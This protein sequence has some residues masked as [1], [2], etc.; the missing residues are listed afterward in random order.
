VSSSNEAGLVWIPPS[1]PASYWLTSPVPGACESGEQP[2]SPGYL[3]AVPH[4]AIYV[5]HVRKAAGTDSPINC[6]AGVKVRV[7][8]ISPTSSPASG[9]A[10]AAWGQ[11]GQLLLVAAAAL[12]SVA[13]VLGD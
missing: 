7:D 5:M 12:A 8:V 3:A 13:L 1:E 10:A 6:T 11:R 4:S 9:A 2:L